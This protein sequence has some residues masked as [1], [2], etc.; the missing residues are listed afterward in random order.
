MGGA[1]SVNVVMGVMMLQRGITLGMMNLD[2]PDPEI[3]ALGNMNFIRGEH[4]E[5][6][7]ERILANAFGFG[8]NNAVVEIG[9]YLP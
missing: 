2:N 7:P 8:G 9:Q 3:L 4:L 5:Y 6:K 1:G